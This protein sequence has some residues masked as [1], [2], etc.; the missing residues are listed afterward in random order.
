MEVIKKRRCLEEFVSRIPGL[1]DTIESTTDNVKSWGKIPKTI[2]LCDT[3][4]KYGTF[5]KIFYSLLNVLTKSQ[6]FKYDLLKDKWLSIDID[7]Y[8]II[9]DYKIPTRGQNYLQ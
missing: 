9:E 3:E 8:C 6:Y 1:F 7:C 4:F 5:M 2:T